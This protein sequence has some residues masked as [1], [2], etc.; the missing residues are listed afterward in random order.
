M[1]GDEIG[2][3]VLVK[4]DIFF[5]VSPSCTSVYLD[6]SEVRGSQ[7]ATVLVKYGTY[8]GQAAFLVWMPELPLDLRLS[9]T[10]L[11]QIRAWRTPHRHKRCRNPL[12]QGTTDCRNDWLRNKRRILDKWDDGDGS[13]PGGSPGSCRLRFQ[14]ARVEVLTRFQ[15]VDH[16]SGREAYLLGRRT[17]VAVTRLVTPFLRVADAHLAS[18]KGTTVR[19][20]RAGRTEV[21]VGAL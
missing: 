11:S 3:S 6:G 2:A 20:L 17:Q 5:L 8:T 18:L 4:F 21:Q 16:N 1:T 7:N 10:K 14:Q 15:S 13:S 19:G 9:D 12:L